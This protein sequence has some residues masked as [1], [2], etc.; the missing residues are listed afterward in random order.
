M[1]SVVATVFF[2][3]EVSSTVIEAL[4]VSMESDMATFT[5]LAV[6]GITDGGGEGRIEG[7]EDGLTVFVG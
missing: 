4:S 3:A 6:V 2:N 5:W 1:F 7:T